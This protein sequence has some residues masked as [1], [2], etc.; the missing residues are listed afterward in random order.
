MDYFDYFEMESVG[1]IIFGRTKLDFFSDVTLMIKQNIYLMH[2]M[3]VNYETFDRLR[4]FEH[5]IG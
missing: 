1:L 2:R 5:F 3:Q 4:Y